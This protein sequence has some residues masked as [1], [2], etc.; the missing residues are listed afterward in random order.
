V[1]DPLEEL[2]EEDEEFPPTPLGSL[3]IVTGV[4]SHETIEARQ[5]IA[6]QMFFM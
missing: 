2:T 6:M 1:L 4:A 5:A 3:P